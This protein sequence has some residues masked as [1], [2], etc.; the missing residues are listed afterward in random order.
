M[1]YISYL[2]AVVDIFQLRRKRSDIGT[3]NFKCVR[4]DVVVFLLT[5]ARKKY[6][7][8]IIIRCQ[9]STV[10]ITTLSSYI[11]I[12]SIL[13][14][15]S[16]VSTFVTLIVKNENKCNTINITFKMSLGNRVFSL[17]VI[18]YGR[19]RTKQV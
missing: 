16:I 2:C 15:K 17:S 7:V 13:T 9:I 18:S 12:G 3:S 14:C 10:I 1:L 5:K 19:Y 11:Y 4:F 8:N 6:L